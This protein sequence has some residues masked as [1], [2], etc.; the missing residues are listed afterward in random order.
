MRRGL[1]AVEQ[2]DGARSVGERHDLRDRV[3]RAERIR[4][5]SDGSDF[6]ARAEALCERGHIERAVVEN[7][8]D[9]D[10]SARSL[11]EQLPWDDV[12]VMF[13]ARDQHLVAAG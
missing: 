5:M 11:A 9:D 6:R 13:E 8:R 10:A 3:D 4:Y 7:R 2:H 12:R 1:R